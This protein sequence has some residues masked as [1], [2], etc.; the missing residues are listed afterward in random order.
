MTPDEQKAMER[1]RLRAD[2]AEARVK[3][4]KEAFD[5]LISLVS[6]AHSVGPDAIIPETITTPLGIPIKARE[7]VDRARAV[8][9]AISK[10]KYDGP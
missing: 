6:V 1:L 3:E 2:E 4:L 8:L 10:E 7:I 9:K 5:L